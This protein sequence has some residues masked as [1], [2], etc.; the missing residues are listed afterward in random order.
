MLRFAND[1]RQTGMEKSY[2]SAVVTLRGPDHKQVRSGVDIREFVGQFVQVFNREA[3]ARPP[4]DE[5]APQLE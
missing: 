1:R 2:I 4:S 5:L 3:A